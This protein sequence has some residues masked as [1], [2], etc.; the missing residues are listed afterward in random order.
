V[1]E[2]DQL[3]AKTRPTN[4]S[5]SRPQFL[6]NALARSDIHALCL[7]QCGEQL[8][9]LGGV[10]PVTLQVSDNFALLRNKLLAMRDMLFGLNQVLFDHCPAHLGFL[11]QA[12]G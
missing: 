6:L 10:V 4:R 1:T 3:P 7:L 12:L 5:F 11:R 8:P 9:G 2:S